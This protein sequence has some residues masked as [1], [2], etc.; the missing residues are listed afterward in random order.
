[1][2]SELY[3]VNLRSSCL[4]MVGIESAVASLDNLLH[5]RCYSNVSTALF[6]KVHR[7]MGEA[8]VIHNIQDL[9]MENVRETLKQKETG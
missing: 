3:R 6:N 7:R 5:Y 8:A 1:M 4:R 2:A 9:V